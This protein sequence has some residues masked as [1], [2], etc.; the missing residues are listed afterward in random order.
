MFFGN[1]KES[2]RVIL[3]TRYP[4]AGTTKKRLIPSLGA[5]DAA[6]LQKELTEHAVTIVRS[7][8]AH[9]AINIQGWFYSL[10]C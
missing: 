4:V 3:Y 5:E 7:L 8:R 9:D 1:K 2:C 10:S 6:K